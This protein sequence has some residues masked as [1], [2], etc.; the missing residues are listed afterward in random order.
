MKKRISIIL[1][2]GLMLFAM[3]KIDLHADES[4]T[5]ISTPQELDNVRKNLKGNYQLA[6]D[7]DMSNYTDYEP[8]G[9]E[10]EGAF[11]GTFNGNGHTIKNL[12]MDY[13]SY[14][15]AGLFGC[16][17]GKVQNVKLENANI[18][19]S[20]YAGGIAGYMDDNGSVSGCTVSGSINGLGYNYD[21]TK[22][23]GGIIGYANGE[24]IGCENKA[25]V[26]DEGNV[27][28][29]GGIV[30]Y[31]SDNVKKCENRGKIDGS[32][33]AGS[34]KGN[35]EDCM[36]YGYSSGYG[37]GSADEIINC[38]NNG[39]SGYC[40][41]G[42]A[43]KIIRCVNTG[44]E[45]QCSN[46]D[47][48]NSMDM[49]LHWEGGYI[50]DSSN[51]SGSYGG[52]LW[53]TAFYIQIAG[54]R[55]EFNESLSNKLLSDCIDEDYMERLDEDLWE[56]ESGW[57]SGLP[58]L[59]ELPKHLELSELAVTLCQGDSVKLKGRVGKKEITDLKWESG[60]SSALKVKQDGTVQALADTNAMTWV[61]ATTSDGLTMRCTVFLCSKKPTRVSI[62]SSKELDMKIG[63][64]K[65]LK[66]T[67]N[68]AFAQSNLTWTSSNPEVAS[69][70]QNGLITAN[71]LGKTEIKVTTDN[72]CEDTITIYVKYAN[73]LTLDK[74][75]IKTGVNQYFE[76][77]PQIEP[78]GSA[79]S[80]SV[81]MRRNDLLTGS[82]RWE[83]EII[84]G[85]VNLR[86]AL[87]DKP[88]NYI[89]TFTT[90]GGESAECNITVTDFEIPSQK[91][92]NIK[93]KISLTPALKPVGVDQT[94]TWS[95][96]DESIATVDQ[97]GHV[98]GIKTGEVQIKAV[99]DTGVEHLCKVIVTGHPNAI[100]IDKKSID[101][102]VGDTDKITTTFTPEG[103]TDDITYE[104]SNT[105]VVTIDNKGTLT[106]KNPGTAM[107]TIT[108][109]QGLKEYCS[110]TV[111]K[112]KVKS[113]TISLKDVNATPGEEIEVPV[114]ISDNPGISAMKVSISYDQNILTPVNAEKTSLLGGAVIKGEKQEDG[115]YNVLW[116]NTK[117][118]NENGVIYKVK[119]KVNENANINSE[120]KLK[121]TSTAGDVCDAQHND[122]ELNDATGVI[123]IKEKLYGDV[124]EDDVL[125]SHD[126][127]LLQQ[128]LTELAQFTDHQL[129]LAD[130]TNDNE[131]N[132]QDLVVLANKVV[133]SPSTSRKAKM[134]KAKVQKV[135][136]QQMEISIGEQRVDKDGYV[137]IPISFKNC[138]GISAFRF[139]VNYDE[140]VLDLLSITGQTDEIN[141]Y[142]MVNLKDTKDGKSLVTWYNDQNIVLDGNIMTLRFKV[143]KEKLGN[144]TEISLL[145]DEKDICDKDLNT[146]DITTNNG[147][148]L[149]EEKKAENP[150]TGSTIPTQSSTQ[151]PSATTEQPQNTNKQTKVDKIFVTAISNNIAAGKKV[152]L[153][154]NISN[155]ATNKSVT[156]VSS[157]KKI[158]T[159]DKNG[160][161]KFN[162]KAAGK[163][164]TITAIANDGSG[165]KATFKL[166]AM[167]GIVKKVTI[168][169]KKSVKAGKI[170]KLKAKV[171]ASKG[172]NKKLKWLS[173]NT[174][175]AI[176][177]TSGKVKALKAGKGKKVKITA[178]ATDGSGK[179]KSVTVKIK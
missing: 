6:N 80:I 176:V 69:I 36:N 128:Y 44:Y 90:T 134:A 125:N 30:G 77:N 82:W 107:I 19:A 52:Y 33:I 31:S 127:L 109:G 132:M 95:S 20:R 115:I 86:K 168:V 99:S 166:K 32:G 173:S 73:K 116:Y 16:L 10:S 62:S 141:D 98:T 12:E 159:V 114:M 48:Y 146:F 65:K 59:K 88:G 43:N 63:E 46:S 124:Y 129:L 84:D 133:S 171:S 113:A 67:F 120:T 53:H 72:G 161:V 92:V 45:Q 170:L 160:V 35:I 34:V 27:S 9:N 18:K 22:Y 68:H 91:T 140:S 118:I 167:K 39:D 145:W 14:K 110:V 78:E 23:V 1:A 172:A 70:D 102:T 137:D 40:G 139:K 147:K 66:A 29:R 8:I 61:K 158:A 5:M 103:T 3:S 93:N 131:V 75:N 162:K 64:T 56:A 142:L 71:K 7:I 104:S 121:V 150:S 155:N 74:T 157:N 105:N 101:M 111:T 26:N 144:G 47:I 169:G 178:M 13:D 83:N 97:N 135:A 164:V 87:V 94:I 76:I 130:M 126:V 177:S 28:H 42:Q 58:M 25:K 138:T 112:K 165:K 38:G 96:M 148:V 37:I 143:N 21:F 179:K 50:L 175:Y 79:D 152:K 151:E 17:D 24:I 100:S 41:I 174:K 123:K 153:T 122:I 2:M 51:N 136:D 108:T 55:K 49:G 163:S 119:F 149:P 11:K 106:A 154:A 4:V 60:D 117:D 85:N 57:N 15:Y 156:W 81:E 89:M 54:K